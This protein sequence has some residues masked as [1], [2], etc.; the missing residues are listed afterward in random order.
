MPS[1]SVMFGSMNF[2]KV[3]GFFKISGSRGVSMRIYSNKSYECCIFNLAD[4]KID[5]EIVNA[6]AN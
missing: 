1:L 5:T 2:Q 4:K 6:Q 3:S